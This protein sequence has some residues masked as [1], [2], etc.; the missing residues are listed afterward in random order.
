MPRSS[1][2]P[3]D[4]I[5]TGLFYGPRRKIRRRCRAGQIGGTAPEGEH[6]GSTQKHTRRSAPTERHPQEIT[7]GT[8]PKVERAR[9]SAGGRSPEGRNRERYARRT[10]PK[11]THKKKAPRRH[12]ADGGLFLCG[13]VTAFLLSSYRSAAA[14]SETTEARSMYLRTIVVDLWPV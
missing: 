8:T 11:G 5:A 3:P 10:T 14:L 6:R 12:A 1:L 4:A 9:K 2:A 7:G 13:G